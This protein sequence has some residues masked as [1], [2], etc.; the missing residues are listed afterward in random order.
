M[1]LDAMLTAQVAEGVVLGELL[2]QHRVLHQEEELA[3][4]VAC[5][6]QV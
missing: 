3:D 1:N 5:I 6:V 2:A 4:L